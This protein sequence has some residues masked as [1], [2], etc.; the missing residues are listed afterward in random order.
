MEHVAFKTDD[1]LARKEAP[2]EAESLLCE[3]L[4]LM[5]EYFIGEIS[6]EGNALLYRLPNGQKFRITAQKA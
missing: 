3:L 5:E 4:P 2:I 6:L 1:E